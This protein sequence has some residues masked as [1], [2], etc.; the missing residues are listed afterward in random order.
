VFEDPDYRREHLEVEIK[1]SILGHQTE[2]PLSCVILLIRPL[3][4]VFKY[5]HIA[6]DELIRDVRVVIIHIL[7]L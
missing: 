7:G 4:D 6:V 1:V 5:Q 3:K 2:S